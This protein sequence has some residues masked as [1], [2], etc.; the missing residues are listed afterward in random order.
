MARQGLRYCFSWKVGFLCPAENPQAVDTGSNSFVYKKKRTSQISRA[1]VD[2]VL[3]I[4][5]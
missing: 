5:V 4:I 3:D 2:V 1:G